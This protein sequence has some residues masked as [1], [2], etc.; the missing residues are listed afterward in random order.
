MKEKTIAEL[1]AELNQIIDWF[2]S[3]DVEL[4]EAISKFEVGQ[5]IAT[6]LKLKLDKAELIIKK[7]TT[8]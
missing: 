4:D 1:Q 8:K 6:E 2:E 7:H 3:D 5:K